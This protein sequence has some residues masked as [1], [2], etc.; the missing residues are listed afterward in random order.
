MYCNLCFREVRI[1]EFFKTFYNS[2]SLNQSVLNSSE[3]TVSSNIICYLLMLKAV[4]LK[5]NFYSLAFKSSYLF[6]K[7]IS[8]NS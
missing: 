6:K 8:N 5:I 3:V 2:D 4:N 1:V 7:K